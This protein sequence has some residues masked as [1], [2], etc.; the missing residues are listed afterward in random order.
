MHYMS[1]PRKQ[2]SIF[3]SILLD[4]H[5]HGNDKKDKFANFYPALVREYYGNMD[6]FRR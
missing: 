4:S 5:F 2:E 6:S 3:F 1:F